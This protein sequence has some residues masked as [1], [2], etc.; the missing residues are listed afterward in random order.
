MNTINKQPS[1]ER[2]SHTL[3]FE[4]FLSDCDSPPKVDW[5]A[6]RFRYKSLASAKT[7]KQVGDYFGVSEHNGG[8]LIDPPSLD[9]NACVWS[10]L[11]LIHGG[12]RITDEVLY[13]QLVQFFKRFNP[14]GCRFDEANRSNLSVQARHFCSRYSTKGFVNTID[15]TQLDP[16]HPQLV[17]VDHTNWAGRTLRAHVY[18]WLPRVDLKRARLYVNNKSRQLLSLALKINVDPL[19]LW[20]PWA[21]LS[22]GSGVSKAVTISATLGPKAF[23][24]MTLAK[25][26]HLMHLPNLE[27]NKMV[28]QLWL[29]VL[30]STALNYVGTFTESN[31]TQCGWLGRPAICD[32]LPTVLL[33][34][35]KFTIY[36]SNKD[37]CFYEALILSQLLA[38]ETVTF[39]P[40]IRLL[41]AVIFIDSDKSFSLQPVL[42]TNGDVIALSYAAYNS[43]SKTDMELVR[44]MEV[45]KFVKDY[46]LNKKVGT[47]LDW[48]N[49]VGSCFSEAEDTHGFRV[50]RGRNK[51]EFHLTYTHV[52]EL[53]NGQPRTPQWY[54]LTE[55]KAPSSHCAADSVANVG[56][57]N[58]FYTYLGLLRFIIHDCYDETDTW[59][60]YDEVALY[61]ASARVARSFE[62]N[63]ADGSQFSFDL[64]PSP[65]WTI[66]YTSS[67]R[68]FSLERKKSTPPL[69]KIVTP[70]PSPKS[71]KTPLLLQRLADL[72]ERSLL[73]QG[74]RALKLK[75][76]SGQWHLDEWRFT[77]NSDMLVSRS[78]RKQL[79]D[80]YPNSNLPSS[81]GLV[82]NYFLFHSQLAFA[83][84]IRSMWTS[85]SLVYTDFTTLFAKQVIESNPEIQL[86]TFIPKATHRVYYHSPRGLD[87]IEDESANF[88]YD[89]IVVDVPRL[90]GTYSLFD[91]SI[92]CRV[93]NG[94]QLM[95]TMDA[96][97]YKPALRV[98]LVDLPYLIESYQRGEVNY[99]AKGRWQ[100]G[101]EVHITLYRVSKTVAQ[102]FAMSRSV[103]ENFDGKDLYA[104]SNLFTLNKDGYDE[105]AIPAAIRTR[106]EEWMMTRLKET[107]ECPPVGD[108]L[109]FARVWESIDYY[110]VN[111]N[112]VNFV[113]GRWNE[114]QA[115]TKPQDQFEH[116]TFNWDKVTKFFDKKYLVKASALEYSWDEIWEILTTTTTTK[117]AY[118]AARYIDMQSMDKKAVALSFA[119]HALMLFLGFS[120]N[121]ATYLARS[122]F[123]GYLGV[124]FGQVNATYLQYFI[125]LLST[126]LFAW[127]LPSFLVIFIK[128]SNPLWR[129][130]VL[131]RICREHQCVRCRGA[132][133]HCRYCD[134]VRGATVVGRLIAPSDFNTA[135]RNREA[136]YAPLADKFHTVDLVDALSTAAIAK[137]FVVR[138]PD[139][140]L[141]SL[142]RAFKTIPMDIP[143]PTV[144]TTASDTRFLPKTVASHPLYPLVALITR[145]MS[146]M[147]LTDKSYLD[148]INFN[149]DRLDIL[150]A[151]L[152]EQRT[153]SWEE[154]LQ[155]IEPNKRADY[156]VGRKQFLAN[157]AS[158][159]PIYTV[160]F[161]EHDKV[162]KAWHPS[163]N[164]DQPWKPRLVCNPVTAAKAIMSHYQAHTMPAFKTYLQRWA[165]EE[166]WPHI[167][168]R[169]RARLFTHA[170]RSKETVSDIKLV[171]P[172]FEDAVIANSDGGNFDVHQCKEKQRRIDQAIHQYSRYTAAKMGYDTTHA[173]AI[174]RYANTTKAKLIYKI[175]PKDYDLKRVPFELRKAQY[176]AT[177]EDSMF[178][179]RFNTTED[180]SA[181]MLLVCLKL[182]IHYGYIDHY[183]VTV[184]GDDTIHIVE[185][186]HLHLFKQ[187]FSEGFST[188]T[189]TANPEVK[190]VGMQL[191][192]LLF[193]DAPSFLSKEF[194]IGRDE[195]TF[196]RQPNRLVATGCYTV[197]ISHDL[198]EAVFN[199]VITGQLRSQI[200]D[201]DPC[202]TLLDQRIVKLAHVGKRPIKKTD[203][204]KAYRYT[205]DVWKRLT[206][207]ENSG[208]SEYS[209]H[210]GYRLL[211]VASTDE[212][213]QHFHQQG[214][215]SN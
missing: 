48:V 165:S 37:D 184:S 23:T 20:Q 180:N 66:K 131:E 4:D 41:Q 33:E 176:E 160:I 121:V 172:T 120:T 94:E 171:L 213:L 52:F 140:D 70:L 174:H 2:D 22:V 39:L 188:N 7:V 141:Q 148:K 202:L 183:W 36:P 89:I 72:S 192:E 103:A 194:T 54:E 208:S 61:C 107:T 45:A 24:D 112:Y 96:P 130:R 113:R 191:K 6:P 155:N 1:A 104:Y 11:M 8:L 34:S 83:A 144:T 210:P 117:V 166:L 159:V 9:R 147:C 185:R 65:Q 152:K 170:M 178:S 46:N 136:T 179:G 145:Q 84:S 5:S 82:N 102:D 51:G 181:R 56:D 132:T 13:P 164:K 109:K 151:C 26:P 115:L 149:L 14:I 157:P 18:L 74:L 212:V 203:L 111:A 87:A 128:W 15:F 211:P 108:I 63:L 214:A 93:T 177:L 200:T 91:A 58:D 21:F 25:R 64:G 50:T 169:A 197:N 114:L 19:S 80:Q 97:G 161:K 116:S 3:T 105:T 162:H 142:Q 110:G 119:Y 101:A 195:V 196:L 124:E 90:A 163:E 154:H 55:V 71:D 10:L 201:G 133:V 168:Q 137:E 53:E 57:R 127:Y 12:C 68:H 75:P 198:T 126:V 59:A 99:Q 173:Q 189:D 153:I 146:P 95:L 76:Q 67:P 139:Q 86:T 73:S 209:K 44:K 175:K 88:G 182:A 106:T 187:A 31:F 190:G 134:G 135:H 30:P 150:E 42:D 118:R 204:S 186:S 62:I 43:T 85:R 49:T 77:V 47:M 69:P 17:I 32:D 123:G 35:D 81:T 122:H 100:V 16:F 98:P 143:E 125:L 156:C 206:A 129:Y 158:L 199:S 167:P 40:Y 60:S 215:S 193:S 138:Q 27:L 29:R 28:Q 92:V 205:D 207:F 79:D 38:C 78:L